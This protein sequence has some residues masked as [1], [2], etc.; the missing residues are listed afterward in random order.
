MFVILALVGGLAAA[1]AAL[2]TASG[3]DD[4][5]L[6]VYN[7]RSHYGGEAA[8]KRFEQETGIKVKLFG[9][10]A[11]ELFERL[12][13][14]GEDTPADVL[15]TVDGANLWQ[16]KEAGLLA[17]V[18]DPALARALPANLRDPDGEFFAISTR[19]R[20]LVR[21]TERVGEN[22]LATYADL[23][24][25]RWKGRVCLRTSNNIYNQSLVA[26]FLAKRGARATERLLRSWMANEPRILGSD[27]D[28]L[29]A[30]AG[31]QCDVSLVNHYYLGRMLKD[32]PDFPV[33]PVWADQDGDG[34]HANVSGAG[35]VATS[36]RPA[37]AARLVAY[38]A[39]PAQQRDIASKSEFPANPDVEPPAHIRSWT[40]FKTDPIDVG[41]AGRQQR[42]A[43]QLMAKVGWQ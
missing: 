20:T 14:E 18:R 38:L 1:V 23:G 4:D 13:N 21:S 34:A 9:G 8:F 25:P 17:P 37:Q 39:Q 29:K 43:V 26:D 31:G 42:A 19:V 28:V 35:V 32:D 10:D 27:V 15:V 7:G 3:G 11:T 6:V 12:R 33:A 2:A 16:A 24:D 36:D 5:A 40:G 30:V 41:A 22:D